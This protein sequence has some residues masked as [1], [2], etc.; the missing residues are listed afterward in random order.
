MCGRFTLRSP[1]NKLLDQ[2]A[3]TKGEPHDFRPRYNIA[4]TQDV[5]IVR[6]GE[7]GEREWVDVRWGLIPSWAKDEKMAARMINARGETVHE[8]PSFRAAFKRRR[9]VIPADGFYEWRKVADG[10]QPFHISL[11][12]GEPF[13]FAGLWERWDKGDGPPLETCT[14]ITT[15][16]NGLLCELHDRMPVILSPPDYDVWLDPA[17]EDPQMLLPLVDAYPGDQMQFRPVSRT[18]NSPKNDSPECLESP[19]G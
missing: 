4:P 14:I 3:C 11:D 13:V 6:T 9:C 19:T 5:A 1:A 2:L 7:D 8:K 10:K 15:E 12:D 18:V 17:L 16:A